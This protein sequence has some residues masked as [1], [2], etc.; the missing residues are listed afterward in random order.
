MVWLR[1]TLHF[2]ICIIALFVCVEIIKSHR[3]D[4]GASGRMMRTNWCGHTGLAGAL[5]REKQRRA[6]TKSCHWP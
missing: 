6:T 1:W 3:A 5:D 2:T 4:L